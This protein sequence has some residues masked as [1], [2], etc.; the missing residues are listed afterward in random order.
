MIALWIGAGLGCVILAATVGMALGMVLHGRR[1]Q[2]EGQ[3]GLVDAQ[4]DACRAQAEN[5]RAQTR[6]ISA[7]AQLAEATVARLEQEAKEPASKEPV[8]ATGEQDPAKRAAAL[9]GRWADGYL[10]GVA[11]A[12]SRL[13]VLP[14]DLSGSREHWEHILEGMGVREGQRI[15]NPIIVGEQ[16]VTAVVRNLEVQFDPSGHAH[17]AWRTEVVGLAAQGP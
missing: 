3:R 1:Q 9:V 16:A 11:M 10:T 4:T 14:G 15:G 7:Q 12:M 6:A 2:G 8:A 17:M 5:L 13:V